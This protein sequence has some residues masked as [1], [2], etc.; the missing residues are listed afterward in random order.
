MRKP[1]IISSSFV[2]W[3]QISGFWS[4]RCLE[5]TGLCLIGWSF[6]H[7]GKKVWLNEFNAIWGAFYCLLWF[8]WRKWNSW[9]F[10]RLQK[11]SLTYNFFLV[12]LHLCLCRC[13]YLHRFLY[14]FSSS[15]LFV[16]CF[17]SYTSCILR[18]CPLCL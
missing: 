7:V 18:L 6:W 13:F 4:L 10:W 11:S 8:F 15:F 14:S 12:L 3:C 16:G 2:T 1:L 17:L 5:L 9:K